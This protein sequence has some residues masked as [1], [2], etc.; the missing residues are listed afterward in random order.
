MSK[1]LGFF[2]VLLLL[3][4]VFSA[5]IRIPLFG[6]IITINNNFEKKPTNSTEKFT[7]STVKNGSVE[8]FEFSTKPPKTPS[9]QRPKSAVLNALLSMFGRF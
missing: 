9:Q 4:G 7:G 3:V 8:N 1:K 2:V 6:G 5:Q